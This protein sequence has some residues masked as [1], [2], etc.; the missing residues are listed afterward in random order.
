MKTF[1]I[2]NVQ[3]VKGFEI[4]AISSQLT[5]WDVVTVCPVPVSS[6]TQLGIVGDFCL[7]FGFVI[8]SITHGPSSTV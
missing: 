3:L 2:E 7:G 6:I 5:Y 1:C 4:T 8:G